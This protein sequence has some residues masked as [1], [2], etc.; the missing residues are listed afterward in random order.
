MSHTAPLI[1]DVRAR[2]VCAPLTQP[3]R[4]AAGTIPAAPLVLIDVFTDR[5][6]AGRA[7]IFGYT[8]VTLEPLVTLIAKLTEM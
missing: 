7:Y 1:T 4:T 8:A 6:V 5:E 2:A 3:I